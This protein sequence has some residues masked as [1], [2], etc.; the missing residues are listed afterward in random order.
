MFCC[1]HWHLCMDRSTGSTVGPACG[2]CNADFLSSLKYRLEAILTEE[3][4]C[5]DHET[6]EIP[7]KPK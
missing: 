2:H 4:K 7:E 1:P 3:I 5:P 6:S